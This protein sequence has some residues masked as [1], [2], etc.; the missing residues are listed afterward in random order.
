[1]DTV[2]LQLD[3]WRFEDVQGRDPI[4]R[5]I[6]ADFKV[7]MGPDN[8]DLVITIQADA[9]QGDEAGVRMAKTT[10]HRLARA[11]ARQTAAWDP[12]ET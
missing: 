1:M 12:E 5:V 8:A 11:V 6:W 4:R 2:D 10:L 9:T 3:N 7:S